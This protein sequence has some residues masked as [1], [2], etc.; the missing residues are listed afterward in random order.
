MLFF[1]HTLFVFF[2]CVLLPP[3]HSCRGV[4]DVMLLLSWTFLVQISEFVFWFWDCY[5]QTSSL[6]SLQTWLA[7]TNSSGITITLK[8]EKDF[9]T[10]L[11]MLFYFYYPFGYRFYRFSST[12]R[13]MHIF[14]SF[15]SNRYN[16]ANICAT[17]RKLFWTILQTHKP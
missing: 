9:N 11:L 17:C 6:D 14:F 16:I 1:H 8:K 7:T 5:K 10:F 15:I 4:G 3:L 12:L 2:V 13:I